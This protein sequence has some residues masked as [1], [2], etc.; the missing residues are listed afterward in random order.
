MP[1]DPCCTPTGPDGSIQFNNGG[2]LGG[3]DA[4]RFDGTGIITD[5]LIA[6]QIEINGDTITNI[7]SQ[8]VLNLNAKGQISTIRVNN[9]GSGYTSVPAITIDPPAAGGVQATADARMGAVVAAAYDR[10]LGYLPGDTLLVV[11]GTFAAP[12][13]LNVE[14]IRIKTATVDSFNRG[15]GYK[16][17]DTLTVADPEGLPPIEV[18]PAPATIIVTRVRLQSPQI[19]NQG[20]GYKT[21][22]QITVF[23]GSGTSAT[24]DLVADE[25]LINGFEE[26]LVGNGG[27]D[28]LLSRLIDPADYSGV[29]VYF[30]D[31]IL[32]G[33]Y[34]LSTVG[35]VTKVTFTGLTPVNPDTISVRLN[36]FRGDGAQTAFVL[37]REIIDADKYE[38]YV[39]INNVA[40]TY[41]TDYTIDPAGSV[42]Q[43]SFSNSA[44]PPQNSFVKVILGGRV[45]DVTMAEPGSYRELPNIVAN[46]AVG[47]SGTGLIVEYDTGVDT[48]Q[49]QNQGPYYQL[50][51][52]N[53]NKA[54]GGSG[55]GAFFDLET[56]INSLVIPQT[57]EGSYTVLPPLI[58]NQASGGSG[59]GATVN[60]SYG[61]T[62]TVVTNAGSGYTQT[63]KVIPGTSPSNNNARLSA[64]MT[65]AR[66]SIGDLVVTGKAKGVDPKVTNV[67]WVTMDGDDD[68]DG[69][70]Q[71]SAKRS[72]KAAAAIA[73][74]F[75]TIFIR[76]GNYYEDNPIY[77]PERV[78]VIGDNLR[79]VNL[80]YGNPSEDFFW[81]NNACYI[82]GVSFRGGLAPGFAITFPPLSHPQLPPGSTGG[83]G[84][85]TTSPYVQN[86]TCF[87]ATGGGMK[88]DGNLASGLKSMVL[89][90]FTQFNQGGPG[91][92]ITN[93]G[94]AQ[95][96]SIFTICTN[97]GT[98]VENGA[99][100]S[101][102]NSN[103][104]FGDIGILSDG[105]SPYLFGGT[106]K[107][108]TG[109]YR[110]DT[111]NVQRIA[112][113]PFVGLVATI[114]DEFSYV[115]NVK[116]I[117]QGVNYQ[118]EPSVLFDPP[119]GYARQQATAVPV[120][121]DDTVD[122]IEVTEEGDGY[123][124][125]AYA[126]IYDI[127][128]VGALVGALIYYG[129]DVEIINGGRSYEVDDVISIAGGVYPD[130]LQ[131]D[132][133]QV[134]V[135]AT[136]A[137]GVVTSVE[138]YHP[139][140]V[141]EYGGGR[142]TELPIVSGALTE[143]T[144]IG[145]GFSCSI[146][147]GIKAIDMA[148]AGTGYVNPQITISGGGGITAKARVDFDRTN[149]SITG[150]TMV[151]QGAGYISQPVIAIRG[152]GTSDPTDGQ[153]PSSIDVETGA[154]AVAEVE[155]GSI[156]RIRIT[157][158]GANFVIDPE[159]TI[160]GGGGSGA[161]VGTLYY[162]AVGV[163]VNNGGSGYKV[164]ELLLVSG[165][166][167]IQTRVIV[168]G[169]TSDLYTSGIVS[170]VQIDRA[171]KY[172]A[173]PTING[174][175]TSATG[176]SLGSGCLLNLSM[177]L[178]E[179]G[180][181][182]GG[183]SY[184]A[185]P[186][187]KLIGGDA[188]SLAF[189]AGRAYYLGTESQ[190]PGAQINPTVDA[191]NYAKAWATNLI[192]NITTLSGMDLLTYPG[193]PYQVGVTPVS[194][195]V[196][197]GGEVAEDAT[198][199]F[200]DNVSRFISDGSPSL[201]PYDNAASLLE[202]N[203]AFLK[204]EV[205]AFVVAT[206]GTGFLTPTQLALCTRDVGL[207][208]DAL[209]IDIGTGGFLRSIR[210]GKSY[211][212][213]ALSKIEGQKV[214]TTAA[215]DYLIALAEDVIQNNPIDPGTLYQ[216]A[217]LQ[218]VD[219]NLGTW[220]NSVDNLKA[221]GAIITE[222]I[223]NGPALTGFENASQ[224]LK[225]NQAFL[226]AEVLAYVANQYPALL[227]AT[228][229]VK[230]GRDIGYIVDAV[231]GD[232]IAAG[233]SPAILESQ[234]YPKYYTI[235]GAS[236]LVQNGGPVQV[237]AAYESVSFRSGKSY[238]SGVT[239]VIPNQS[240]E[241][242]ASI[243]YAKS[244]CQ[245]IVNN[246]VIT[247]LQGDVAQTFGAGSALTIDAVGALFDH[248]TRF[249]DTVDP[250][251]V[252]ALY[253]GC[254]AIMVANKAAWQAQIA[255]W[256]AANPQDPPLDPGQID[257]CNTDVGLIIDE[258]MRDAQRG[259]FVG[260]IRS[261][262][263]YWSAVSRLIPTSELT[264]TI[265]AINELKSLVLADVAATPALDNLSAS[266]DIITHILANGP[267]MA[268]YND[269]SQLLRQNKAFVQA[270]V[271]EYVLTNYPGFL[272]PEQL[273]LCTR[274]AGF[275]VDSIAS[276]LV[277]AGGSPVPVTAENETTVTME[278]ATDYSPLDSERVNFYQVSVASAS[279]H[280]FEYVG[281]GTD[282]NTC[283]PQL[284]GV[285]IQEN[286]VVMRRGGRVY[287]TSTD[288]KGDF[289]IGEGLVINQN[290]GTL[291][292]RVFAKSLFGLV[293][294][295]I[296]SIESGG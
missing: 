166:T 24:A 143:T 289:R 256:V 26:N 233:G 274:D 66:V 6:D 65:G 241:T 102:S 224:L 33:G 80:Y 221:A 217:I 86:C 181:I 204:A 68:N 51:P 49:L 61:V 150:I 253:N 189:S 185:G 87:N 117:D 151:N 187:I 288:H 42:S 199:A 138:I 270:E 193:A 40:Q 136:T 134:K 35:L 13:Q 234:L 213:G 266:F 176:G 91:I 15:T 174:V 210:A 275:I 41:L 32:N 115:D 258:L 287:Y 164:N 206:Y 101:I 202:L 203:K 291:S 116:V 71:D 215:I 179:I 157:N 148:S 190:I 290:T 96:V 223:N 242:V 252:Q 74:P 81:V 23:G 27:Q 129:K 267:E 48:V 128:G 97:I 188:H 209:S 46:P 295:F 191:I 92:Y 276:D 171:G 265:D 285:P 73:K 16:P 118:S 269:A 260:A 104:S 84:R 283:L 186:R 67:I 248:I 159:I 192:Q 108:G 257:R 58:E 63:P 273:A 77:L 250:D 31:A 137:G 52:L 264:Y 271:R 131:P 225:A 25:I 280:T 237:P 78:T 207:L 22:D 113:R 261:G 146:N 89:D 278:E 254:Q 228:Q 50:P 218:V 244:L 85:I 17:N 235:S 100:C 212:D 282:I 18:R 28:Y 230:C 9:P 251:T 156:S 227:D 154:T 93:Q 20:R 56:E 60:L 142:Y 122:E 69:L 30:N 245:N 268:P 272:S 292:G 36:A 222:I 38:V 200:F 163:T 162:Q 175:G 82:A 45:T 153:D 114:G 155:N 195:I 281:A 103:T 4:A 161:V 177:G 201:T 107:P 88:V 238:W 133:L 135:L 127:S 243:N 8:G 239:S 90:A 147:F 54:T 249:I 178:V 240:T 247:P 160:S 111:L 120:L 263:A 196:L 110:V 79:R 262:R 59:T 145:S 47:G 232:L 19:V 149:G 70:S 208:V 3:S 21:F 123:T 167:G 124:G 293:T 119:K 10:G 44:I 132:P 72:V 12:T 106:I 255:L 95:L 125:G 259:G 99:T 279:S 229:S 39:T 130:L 296:L 2:F 109:R 141:V 236:P 231:S 94:Y 172:S 126:T 53:N 180:L 83:A 76:S 11:G 216:S 55:F 14:T 246:V 98:W 173:M 29:G 277:G 165:G 152:G 43:I 158:P 5:R 112:S 220:T 140:D 194:D 139:T 294:P 183:S 214:E 7:L 286:E 121:V 219:A 182:S 64:E 168:T 226:Q 62:N 1:E 75:T 144:G 284:G 211:W 198:E 105:I 184:T 37:S 205:T 169:V 34:S 170:S 197:S 57:G